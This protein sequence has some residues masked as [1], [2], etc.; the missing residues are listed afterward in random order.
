MQLSDIKS[1]KTCSS[2]YDYESP[3]PTCDFLW[4]GSRRHRV[5][6]RRV[7]SPRLRLDITECFECQASLWR[8]FCDLVAPFYPQK[9]NQQIRSTAICTGPGPS[10][11]SE[12]V[13][14]PPR[15][16][17]RHCWAYALAMNEPLNLELLTPSGFCRSQAPPKKLGT[18]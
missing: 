13:S 12:L 17:F 9:K 15:A 5:A 11:S 16:H 14:C 2:M 7:V 18:R 4:H 8:D 3:M 1:P 6:T 10:H